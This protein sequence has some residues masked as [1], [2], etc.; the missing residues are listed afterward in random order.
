M[1]SRTTRDYVEET[2][3]HVPP[4]RVPDKKDPRRT[5]VNQAHTDWLKR[6]MQWMIAN[7]NG[8]IHE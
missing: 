4:L 3:D 8:P 2:G 5:I 1:A 6:K 7:G